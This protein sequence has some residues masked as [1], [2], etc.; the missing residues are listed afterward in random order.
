M[1]A[2]HVW[3][4][5]HMCGSRTANAKADVAGDLVPK[6]WEA[7]RVTFSAV[8]GRLNPNNHRHCFELFGLDFMVD[9]STQACTHSSCL[10]GTTLI[11]MV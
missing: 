8:Q 11:G 1:F 6:M 4:A 5:S 3:H 2:A 9:A 7:A 10:A